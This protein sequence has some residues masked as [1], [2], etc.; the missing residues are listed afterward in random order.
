M[1]YVVHLPVQEPVWEPAEPSGGDDMEEPEE[2]VPL[3]DIA[4]DSEDGAGS[5]E[6]HTDQKKRGWGRC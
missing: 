2:M 1:K 4:S 5:S 6:E 3:E